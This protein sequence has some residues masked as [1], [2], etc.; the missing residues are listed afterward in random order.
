MARTVTLLEGNK[1]DGYSLEL[2]TLRVKNL[3]VDGN[4]FDEVTIVAGVFNVVLGKTYNAGDVIVSS[5]SMP[6]IATCSQ[7]YAWSQY[8][9]VLYGTFKLLHPFKVMSIATYTVF[10]KRIS[11]DYEEPESW[12]DCNQYAL[13]KIPETSQEILDIGVG[14]STFEYETFSVIPVFNPTYTYWFCHINKRNSLFAHIT[15]IF[16]LP[17]SSSID[18]YAKDLNVSVENFPRRKMPALAS[19]Q[20]VYFID[21]YESLRKIETIELGYLNSAYNE[22]KYVL[23]YCTRLNSYIGVHPYE[24]VI[25]NDVAFL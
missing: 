1:T 25:G 4:A 14:N 8:D 2:N 10:V 20:D 6:R 12:E 3:V 7:L 17:T 24:P 23:G 9:E 5:P 18:A 21:V 15:R 16:D 11:D 22:I 19:L 13:V